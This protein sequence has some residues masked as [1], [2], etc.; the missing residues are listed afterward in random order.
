MIVQT[1]VDLRLFGLWDHA[2]AI[3]AVILLIGLWMQKIKN[4]TLLVY[5]L[6]GAILVLAAY[7]RL[8][9]GG[10]QP[11][12]IW[13]TTALMTA[14]FA[15]LVIQRG[16][17]TSLPLYRLTLLLPLLALVTVPWQVGSVYAGSTLAAATAI[18]LLIQ[19]NNQQ[20]LPVYLAL[21]A[22]NTGIYLWIPGLFNTYRL[23]QIYTVPMA[24][25]VLLMLQ[26]HMLELK[27]SV[28]SAVR[29]TA[30]ATLYAGTAL[31]V[32]LRP[33]FYVFALALGLSLIGI[34]LGIALRV[35][36]FLFTGVIFFLLN[37]TGQLVNFYPQ[38]RLSKAI[39][40]M[41]L[42]GVIA[43]GM[44]WFSMQR[45]IIMRQIRLIR[46]DLAEWE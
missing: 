23:V 9:W 46:V 29:F 16:A 18:F 24:I 17:S 44:I 22:C 36:A 30:L 21:L 3:I 41:V 4:H 39:L 45:E 20:S 31:D 6:G 33:E 5:T 43:G 26:L 25:T 28:L 13:D 7:I 34:I 10:L 37:I 38:E 11:F 8:I 2:A 42:G 15:L 19:R 27:P 40:L 1:D 12:T 35:R 32:F 14:G